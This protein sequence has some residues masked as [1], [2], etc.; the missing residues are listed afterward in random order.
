MM[1]G[2]NYGAKCTVSG[3]GKLK[4]VRAAERMKLDAASHLLRYPIGFELFLLVYLVCAL[5]LQMINIY[6]TVRVVLMGGVR[7]I[8]VTPF[9]PLCRTST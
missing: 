5:L 6:K 2:E 3:I 7:Y 8:E 4:G 9:L 1:Y